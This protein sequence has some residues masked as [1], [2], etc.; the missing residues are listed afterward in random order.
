MNFRSSCCAISNSSIFFDLDKLSRSIRFVNLADDAATGNLEKILSR[1]VAEVERH[2]PGLVFVDSF[3]SV[4]LAGADSGI[5]YVGLQQFIQNLG[6][7]MT[8][9]QGTTFLIGQCFTECGPNPIFTV[10]DGL[11]WMRQSVQG[12]SVVRKMEIMKIRGQSSLLG[13]HTFR[14]SSVGGLDVFAPPQLA[15]S[16]LTFTAAADAGQLPMGNAELHEMMGGGLP[17]G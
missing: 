6:V 13:V 17:A 15:T 7:T 9:W 8:R 14:M 1:I 16:P 5:S 2:E 12:D 4:V 3:R 11:I 10:A